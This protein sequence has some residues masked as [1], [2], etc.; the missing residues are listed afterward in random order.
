M[1]A[2]GILKAFLT[3]RRKHRGAQHGGDLIDQ[4]ADD[5]APASLARPSSSS[6]E[7]SAVVSAMNFK[8]DASFSGCPS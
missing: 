1:R 4:S 7:I 6:R 8:R 2:S 5:G 3:D